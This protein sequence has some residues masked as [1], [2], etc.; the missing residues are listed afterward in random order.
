MTTSKHLKKS[1]TFCNALVIKKIDNFVTLLMNI[2]HN[3]VHKVFLQRYYVHSKKE[4][5]LLDDIYQDAE[6]TQIIDV[7]N[8]KIS[9]ST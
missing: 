6:G 7:E 8:M 2:N 3:K 4:T 1:T 5:W 9:Y